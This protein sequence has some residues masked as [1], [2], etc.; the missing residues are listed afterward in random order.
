MLFNLKTCAKLTLSCENYNF[1]LLH[2]SEQTGICKTQI[3]A[4]GHN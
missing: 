3:T 4:I 1:M 2:C